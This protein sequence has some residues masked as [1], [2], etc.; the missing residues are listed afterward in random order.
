MRDK[1]YLSFILFYL[2]QIFKIVLLNLLLFFFTIKGNRN[3]CDISYTV[4][5]FVEGD[6][7]NGFD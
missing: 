3:V 5:E 7:K 2:P 6:L 1:R 4:T